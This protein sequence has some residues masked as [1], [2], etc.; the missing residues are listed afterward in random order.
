MFRDQGTHTRRATEKF[1]NPLAR[2]DPSHRRRH[3]RELTNDLLRGPKSS[4]V[5]AQIPEYSPRLLP[6]FGPLATLIGQASSAARRKS[7]RT[8]G[9]AARSGFAAAALL[10]FS[11]FYPEPLGRCAPA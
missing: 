11:G 2:P 9:A 8:F 5:G 10:V 3:S 1:R 6:S 4:V 7:C